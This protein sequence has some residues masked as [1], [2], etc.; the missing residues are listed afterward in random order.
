MLEHLRFAESGSSVVEVCEDAVLSLERVVV[1]VPG[2]AVVGVVVETG[3]ASQVTV[4]RD[5]Q[6]TVADSLVEQAGYNILRVD[7]GLA[8]DHIVVD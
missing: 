2:L 4:L 6:L 8:S 7:V 5:A 3:R 1:L